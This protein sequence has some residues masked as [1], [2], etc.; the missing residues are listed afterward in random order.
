MELKHIIKNYTDFPKKGILFRDINPLLEDHKCF[1]FI[2]KELKNRYQDIDI[3]YIV[4]IESRGFIFGS[5]LAK[6]LKKGF[7]VVRKEGKLPGQTIKQSYNIEYGKATM[8]MQKNAIRKND[9]VIIIDD[10]LENSKIE[11]DK[12]MFGIISIF[13][14]NPES[15]REISIGPI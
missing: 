2:I 9:K 11:F 5:T 12:S 1:N 6:E 3:K 13:N 8:E 15:N 7:I 10:L 14:T 4:G